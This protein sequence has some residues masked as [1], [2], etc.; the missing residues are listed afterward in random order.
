MDLQHRGNL[1]YHIDCILKRDKEENI[2]RWWREGSNR[3]LEKI[4]Q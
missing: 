2:W 4:P 3:R 1:R